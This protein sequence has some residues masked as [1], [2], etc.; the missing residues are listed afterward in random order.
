MT[1]EMLNGVGQCIEELGEEV[2]SA[3][4][5]ECVFVIIHEQMN[6]FEKRRAER[7]KACVTVI[8]PE[9]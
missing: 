4:D 3:A 5:M 7:E 2:V 9:N 6:Q 8:Y 1:C